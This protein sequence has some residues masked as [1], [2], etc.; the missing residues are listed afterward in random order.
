[1]REGANHLYKV[2]NVVYEDKT[3]WPNHFSETHLLTSLPWG[4]HFNVGKGRGHIHLCH[5]TGFKYPFLVT[6]LSFY[7]WCM[8]GVSKWSILYLWCINLSAGSHSFFLF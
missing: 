4:E 3:S 1:L 7:F 5:G 6:D 8:P 2:A